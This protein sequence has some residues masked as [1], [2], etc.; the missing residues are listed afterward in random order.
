MDFRVEECPKTESC[1]PAGLQGLADDLFD[2]RATPREDADG[3]HLY[4]NPVGVLTN[5][6]PYPQLPCPDARAVALPGDWSS[7]ARY[8]RAIY[9]KQHMAVQTEGPGP[10]FHLLDSVAVPRGPVRTDAGCCHFTRYSSC[11]DTAAGIYYYTTYENPAITA[12]DM[13]R[14]DLDGVNLVRYPM[15]TEMRILWQNG[16]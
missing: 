9:V 14:E 8:R 1:H 5:E 12:V 15:E 6:P 10:F 7:T 2:F 11:C 16:E 4:E 13:M 3:L